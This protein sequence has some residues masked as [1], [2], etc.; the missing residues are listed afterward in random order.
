MFLLQAALL[1]LLM[2]HIGGMTIEN[3]EMEVCSLQ[4]TLVA[5]SLNKNFKDAY[6][7]YYIPLQPVGIYENSILV[8]N[9]NAEIMDCL[10]QRDIDYQ[11]DHFVNISY[12]VSI[13][14]VAQDLFVVNYSDITDSVLVAEN[15]IKWIFFDEYF[16]YRYHLFLI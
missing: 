7:Y 4:P 1:S 13:K 10:N 2:I 12:T 5:S 15:P 11:I 16:R 3:D 8:Y 14:Y 6:L 9:E